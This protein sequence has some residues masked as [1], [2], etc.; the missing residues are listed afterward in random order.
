M[1]PDALTMLIIGAVAGL[2]VVAYAAGYLE[3]RAISL[4]RA[5]RRRVY[6]PEI[7]G[8]FTDGPRPR[9][10]VVYPPLPAHPPRG[11]ETRRP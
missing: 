8:R 6:G 7:I 4:C 2:T 10:R 11:T 9:P 1:S 3:D 5:W